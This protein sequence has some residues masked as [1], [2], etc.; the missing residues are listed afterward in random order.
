MGVS[1]G[2]TASKLEPLILMIILLLFQPLHFL[3][4]VDYQARL[5]DDYFIFVSF[6]A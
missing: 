2:K 3:K 5:S 1:K 4:K 6:V